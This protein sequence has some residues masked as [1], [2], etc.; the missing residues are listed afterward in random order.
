MKRPASLNFDNMTDNEKFLY[1][2]GL[3]Y[4]TKLRMHRTL[5]AVSVLANVVLCVGW[6]LHG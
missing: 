6:W 4:F 3:F 1:A 5:L 2:A